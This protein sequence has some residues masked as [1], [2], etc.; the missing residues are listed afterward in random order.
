MASRPSSISSLPA[1]RIRASR[2]SPLY[3][4]SQTSPTSLQSQ[5]QFEKPPAV[6]LETSAFFLVASHNSNKKISASSPTPEI[7]KKVEEKERGYFHRRLK[8]DPS[9]GDVKGID[10]QIRHL[11]DGL[12]E[13]E[14][15]SSASLETIRA[16]QSYP[17]SSVL[18]VLGFSVFFFFFSFLY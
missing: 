4:G 6:R 2:Y 18:S 5:N 10:V 7:P 8:S 3:S 9:C 14:K 13:E 11:S 1:A 16:T 12:E 17:S 15:V